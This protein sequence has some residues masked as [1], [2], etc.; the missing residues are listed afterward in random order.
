MGFEV[1][2][3]PDVGLPEVILQDFEKGILPSALQFDVIPL[4]GLRD[5]LCRLKV[6]IRSPAVFIGQL[7]CLL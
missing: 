1:A 4:V 6:V 7:T 5:K 2:Y 3:Y